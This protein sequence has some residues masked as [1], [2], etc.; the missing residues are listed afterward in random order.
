MTSV[1]NVLLELRT[2]EIQTMKKQW[3][4]DNLSEITFHKIELATSAQST[5]D[6]Q[7]II[8]QLIN[9]EDKILN[10]PRGLMLCYHIWG[11]SQT[12]QMS[13]PVWKR[14]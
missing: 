10:K 13:S 8:F 3:A 9:S 12:C 11:L 1:G 4:E 5:V 14:T 2:A 7:W 6:K